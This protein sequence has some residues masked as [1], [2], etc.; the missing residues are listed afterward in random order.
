MLVTRVLCWMLFWL[1]KRIKK[2][3]MTKKFTCF[4]QNEWAAQARF[5]LAPSAEMLFVFGKG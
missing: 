3:Q 2:H 1:N 4:N 5:D